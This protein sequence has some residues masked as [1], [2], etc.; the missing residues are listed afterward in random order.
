[1]TQIDWRRPVQYVLDTFPQTVT[2]GGRQYQ[3][4]SITRRPT[5]G[6]NGIAWEFTGQAILAMRFVD[7]LYGETRFEGPAAFYLAQVA[8][9]QA[10]APFTDGR[11]LVASTLDTG[12]TLPPIE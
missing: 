5:A 12:D 9:A 8:R 4:F 11:G 10:S 7:T 6:P 1:R 3:G 2:A